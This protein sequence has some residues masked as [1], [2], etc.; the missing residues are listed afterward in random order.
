MSDLAICDYFHWT[1]D[2]LRNISV[3]DYFGVVSYMKKVEREQ[4]KAYRKAKRNGK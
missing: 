1:L 3:K 4:K 2:Y